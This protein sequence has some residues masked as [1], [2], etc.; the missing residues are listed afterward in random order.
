MHIPTTGKHG[1]AISS[2][3]G[4]SSNLIVTCVYYQRY[5]YVSNH[6]SRLEVKLSMDRIPFDKIGVSERIPLPSY[7]NKMIIMINLVPIT[8]VVLTSM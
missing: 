4:K 3:H 2:S 5:T 8:H 6:R 7:L 1:Q